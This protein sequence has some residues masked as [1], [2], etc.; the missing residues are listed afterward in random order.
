MNWPKIDSIQRK[1]LLKLI[2]VRVYYNVFITYVILSPN[3]WILKN[4]ACLKIHII[5]KLLSSRVSIL[6]L[7]F[8]IGSHVHIHTRVGPDL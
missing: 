1:I 2:Q 3:I 8:D 4:H 7:Y 6:T 5:A